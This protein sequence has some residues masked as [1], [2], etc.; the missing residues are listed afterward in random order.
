[1]R[2]G[3]DGGGRPGEP[4][5]ADDAAEPVADRIGDQ[6]VPG[7]RLEELLRHRRI[8]RREVASTHPLRTP[9]QLVTLAFLA[10]IGAGTLLLM[11]P[12]STSGPGG[13]PVRTALFT[14]TSA[15]C[16][17]GLTTVD[18][19]TYWSGFGEAVLL[20][21]VQLGGLGVMTFASLL[22]LLVSGRL[23]LRSRLLA[24]AETR[25]LDLGTVRRVVV[26]LVKISATIQSVVFVALTLRLWLGY[27]N[28][29][30]HAA[31]LGL[32]HAVSAYNNAGFSLWS[33]SLVGFSTDPWIILPIAGAVILGGIGYPVLLELRASRRWRRWSLHTKLTLVT[34]GALLVL[35]PLFIW[36]TE[37]PHRTVGQHG[38]AGELLAA[39]F[40]GVTAR[41]AGFATFDYAAAQPATLLASVMLMFVGGGAASTAGGIKVTTLA[42]L[43]LAV[44]AEVRGDKDITAFK[45]R[46]SPATGRQALAVAMIAVA[47]LT[48]ATLVLL[49]VSAFTFD[50]ALF[51]VTSAVT[52][53]GLSTGITPSVPPAGQYL[54]I[55]LMVLGRL[56]P[57]SV[58]SS[59]A[60]R[61]RFRAYRY[62]EA[63]PVVG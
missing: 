6:A 14:A 1:M 22:G 57:V 12:I 24:Q 26:G 54:L 20:V 40:G 16:V 59:L 50:Q 44:A 21:L 60:L 4:D 33:D 53:T 39:G 27:D 11:L 37:H 5:V 31:Y 18:T 38:L 10:M 56:G 47:T 23:G 28:S 49:E 34:T 9:G 8:H 63:R 52:T 2:P 17:T 43:T 61:Q 51:E 62:P 29:L 7:G 58:A 19:A 13:A 30:R 48:T 42:V 15:A 35:G 41:S 55:A 46:I 45:R 32:F 36:L 25:T 3:T